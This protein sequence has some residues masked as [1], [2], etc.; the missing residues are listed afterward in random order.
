[1]I[2]SHRGGENSLELAEGRLIVVTYS[3]AP[4]RAKIAYLGDSPDGTQYL[5]WRLLGTQLEG[6][7]S[8]LRG[9]TSM[10]HIDGRTL[11]CDYVVIPLIALLPIVLIWPIAWG[12][13]IGSI[14]R[15]RKAN[16]CPKCGYDLR[17]SRQLCPECGQ[18]V[19]RLM[20]DGLEERLIVGDDG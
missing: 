5:P 20:D 13:R 10:R 18:A 17:E 4:P 12:G 15:R 14:E 11:K 3:A 1:M 16:Q 8:G 19:M 9:E 7:R 6:G 2:F